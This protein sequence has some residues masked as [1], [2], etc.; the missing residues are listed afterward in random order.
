MSGTV[1]IRHYHKHSASALYLVGFIRAGRVYYVIVGWK[2]LRKWLREST[3]ASSKGGMKQIRVYVPADDQRKAIADG[4]AKELC[5]VE[6]LEAQETGS[7][8]N[9]DKFEKIIAETLA[10]MV[11][12][13]TRT[14]FYEAGDVTLNGEQVQVKLHDATLTDEKV[15][16]HMLEKLR[17]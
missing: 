7:K 6:T 14:P 10:G 8:N 2:Q 16:K 17:G 12:K 5:S 9:G 15:I 11:W 13:K 4:S 1:I 3:M